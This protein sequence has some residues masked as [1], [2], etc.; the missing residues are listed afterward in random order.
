MAP[1]TG[2]AFVR[3]QLCP[4]SLEVAVPALLG[5]LGSK[6]PP[7]TMPRC[8]SRK[9][10]VKAPALGE[11]S[12]GVLY[13]FQVSPP[14]LVVRTLAIVAPPVQIQAFLPPCVVTQVPLDAKEVSPGNAGG[15]LILISC[16]VVP[17][18]VRRSGNTPLTE[19]LWA[20]PRRGVQNPIPS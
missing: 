6:S 9:S 5:S 7:P 17:S 10:I 12:R 4:P 8:G 13:A 2:G 11:L 14:S 1:V 16:H 15:M 19:S 20:M 18:V 3:V